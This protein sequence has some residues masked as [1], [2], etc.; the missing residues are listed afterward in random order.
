R[1]LALSPIIRRSS[2]S[3]M[4]SASFLLFDYSFRYVHTISYKN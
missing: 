3:F 1:L 2:L 4:L